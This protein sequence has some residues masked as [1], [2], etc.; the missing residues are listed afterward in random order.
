[1]KGG[2]RSALFVAAICGVLIGAQ[3]PGVCGEILTPQEIARISTTGGA[4]HKT[5]LSTA[6][7]VRKFGAKGDGK[8]DDTAAF[9]AARKQGRNLYAPS[10][11]YRV[12]L[13]LDGRTSIHG[14][15]RRGTTL[16]PATNNLPVIVVETQK[17]SDKDFAEC[18]D[19]TIDCE[20]APGSIGISLGAT[21]HAG[22]SRNNFRNIVIRN[23]DLYG[24]WIRDATSCLFEN[25]NIEDGNGYGIYIDPERNTQVC[26]FINCQSRQNKVGGYLA[27]G[28]RYVFIGCV[29]ESN[30]ETGLYLD[31][32]L[33]SGFAYS[34]FISCWL[35]N[36]GYR[37]GV[38]GSAS[39]ASI[40]LDAADSGTNAANLVFLTS[41]ISSAKGASDVYAR[42]A[43]NVLFDR[44]SFSTLALGGFTTNKLR[45]EAA[46][47]LSVTL[48]QCGELNKAPTPA[49][50][51]SFPAVTVD[52]S[53]GV[54]GGPSG[55]F[56]EY[57]Y[58]GRWFTNRRIFGLSGSPADVLA[59]AFTGE[60]VLDRAEDKLYAAT[61]TNPKD[62]RAIAESRAGDFTPVVKGR[63]ANGTATYQKAVGSFLRIGNMVTACGTVSFSGHTGRGAM[64]ISGLPFR[65][66]SEGSQTFPASI[67][68]ENSGV[69]K[70][71]SG[72]AEHGT[73]EMSVHA[74]ARKGG[75]G[76]LPV[77]RDG[78]ISFNVTY[79]TE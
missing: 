77:P 37:P 43:Q 7:D 16:K 53:D 10:G 3:M 57:E 33:S 40:Y 15:S 71:W 66:Q 52:D 62:W 35:E 9:A 8:T 48:R 68:A 17:S 13:T 55:F 6:V 14:D 18:S 67:L 41:T 36:N 30:R 63:D 5:S 50:Y 34:T 1:M 12:N 24:I 45:R 49:L 64:S 4:G 78:T 69:E 39:A 19:L 58:Q 44:C 28:N 21:T 20:R 54:R 61:G 59:P 76:P 60:V 74:V 38:A 51:A 31:R 11:V 73:D 26:Q 42:R 75:L 56:Y 22:N 25:V 46:S 27:S 23:A 29:F 2:F 72:K 79:R 65:V 70:A 32:K 47:N